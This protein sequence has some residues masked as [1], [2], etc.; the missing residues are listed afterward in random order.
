MTEQTKLHILR[1]T[2]KKIEG[3]GKKQIKIIEDQGEKQIK[4]LKNRVEIKFLE[5]DQKSI[6]S[7]F[8]KVFVNQKAT[9]ELKIVEI[10]IKHDR[11]YL[12]YKTPNKKR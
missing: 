12:I 7:L 10:K 9:Y 4:A 6:A 5:T 11:N 8:L 2:K 3:Q 1:K